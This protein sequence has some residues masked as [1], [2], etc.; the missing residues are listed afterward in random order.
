M[1]FVCEWNDKFNHFVLLFKRLGQKSCVQMIVS[2]SR[3]PTYLANAG[4]RRKTPGVVS[5]AQWP[6]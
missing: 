5:H 1:E 2:G 4:I 3:L 6:F